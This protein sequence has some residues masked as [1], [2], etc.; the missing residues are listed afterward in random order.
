MFLQTI[1]NRKEPTMAKKNKN[2]F[3]KVIHCLFESG[4]GFREFEVSNEI[5]EIE[6]ETFNIH[7][8]GIIEGRKNMA[9]DIAIL[10]KELR[11][12]ISEAKSD[13]EYGKT[14]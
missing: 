14:K 6:K 7:Y 2:A 13:F 10:K 12:S 4:V 9:G 8:S 3:E 11:K 1:I 5:K